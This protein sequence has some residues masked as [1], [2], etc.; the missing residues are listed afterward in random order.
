MPRTRITTPYKRRKP[1]P[2]IVRFGEAGRSYS[3]DYRQA[4]IR[5]EHSVNVSSVRNSSGPWLT[6][7]CHVQ[8][9]YMSGS[10][11]SFTNKVIVITGASS[12]V[13]RAMAIE[14]A[15][16]GARLV[17]AARREEALQEV[18][19]ECKSLGGDAIAVPTDV[20]YA[21]TMQELAK[22]AYRFGGKIDVWINNAGVLA[23]G[24]LEQTPAEVHEEV[25]KTNLL[26]YIHGAYAVLPYFKQQDFGLLINN[27]S[28]GGWF[29]TPY[30]AAYTA[31]KFGLRGFSESLKG[32]LSAYP[33]I[34]VC[35]LYPGFLDTPGIQHAANFTGHVLKPA[36]PVYDPRKVARAVVSIIRDPRPSATIGAAA[37]FLK[38]AH[39][40]F[41][42][43]SRN[44]TAGLIRKYL[45]Q[46]DPI[47]HTSG[48]VLQ[49]VDY[50]RGI[51]GGWRN[52]PAP[53][54]ACCY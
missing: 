17:V 23:A 53:R 38:L 45:Q 54:P 43:L 7:C 21:D 47:D 26:G 14:L 9:R 12:G 3:L 35:D 11:N 36:P 39:S 5:V 42:V 44:I 6:C 48:N 50:G 30:A 25:I 13:G 28:V 10:R 2:R 34:E 15:G 27:I 49:P 19:E 32:E 33:H 29:P 40:G 41:P 1:L 46:A 37:A 51:D 31:S 20:R 4:P 8:K 24:P 52:V 18:A 16:H 22:A